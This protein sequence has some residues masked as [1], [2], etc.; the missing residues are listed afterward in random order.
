MLKK[1]LKKPIVWLLGALALVA[2]YIYGVAPM[3]AEHSAN[4]TFETNLTELSVKA[5]ALSDKLKEPAGQTLTADAKDK[6][7]RFLALQKE[8]LTDFPDTTKT[9][10]KLDEIMAVLTEMRSTIAGQDESL[11]TKVQ[12]FQ[13][14][15][16]VVVMRNP[17]LFAA[18]QQEVRVV[19]EEVMNLYVPVAN[20]ERLVDNVNV[21]VNRHL[22]RTGQGTGANLSADELAAIRKDVVKG[23]LDRAAAQ[24]KAPQN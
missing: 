2:V 16:S 20:C 19:I 1:W 21:A 15:L 13:T 10:P 23:L 3:I 5:K 17:Q 12:D 24:R 14:A 11:K 8:Y 6:L 9:G 7:T 4:Q 22:M 18:R